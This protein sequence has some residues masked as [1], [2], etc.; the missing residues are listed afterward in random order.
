MRFTIILCNTKIQYLRHKAKHYQLKYGGCSLVDPRAIPISSNKMRMYTGRL[1]NN[2]HFF[3]TCLEA[4]KS[5][6]RGLA[7]LVSGDSLLPGS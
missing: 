1:V 5:K 6:V 4:G 7:D 3:L 2:R